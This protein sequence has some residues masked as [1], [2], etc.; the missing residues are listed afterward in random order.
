MRVN[1]R[2]SASKMVALLGSTALLVG[3]LIVPAGAS[4]VPDPAT[5]NTSFAVCQSYV[6]SSVAQQYNALPSGSMAESLGQ[7]EQKFVDGLC[8]GWSTSVAQ[9]TSNSQQPATQNAIT[10]DTSDAYTQMDST[11][12]FGVTATGGG[13][14][15]SLLMQGFWEYNGSDARGVSTFCEPTSSPFDGYT[16]AETYCAWT[17]DGGVDF[18]NPYALM[19]YLFTITLGVGPISV[20][21]NYWYWLNAYPNGTHEFGCNEC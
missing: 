9:G 19:R 3:V 17:Y 8:N 2:Y 21:Q 4:S 6:V 5:T 10:P 16:Y 13:T 18:S 1:I 20:S 14:I 11:W 12:N 7:L 15:I